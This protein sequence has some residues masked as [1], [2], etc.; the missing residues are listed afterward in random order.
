MAAATFLLP[1][2]KVDAE[3]SDVLNELLLLTSAV[4]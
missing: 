1:C 2:A 4:I 3:P